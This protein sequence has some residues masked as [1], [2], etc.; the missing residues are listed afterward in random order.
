VVDE[1][2]RPVGARGIAA[3]LTPMVAGWFWL[4]RT[5]ERGFSLNPE[6]RVERF[7]DSMLTSS[8]GNI[9]IHL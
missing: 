1:S 9:G 6:F 2:I 5:L 4:K 3:G 8:A 7:G